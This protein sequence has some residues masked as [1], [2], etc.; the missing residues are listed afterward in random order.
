MKNNL[1]SF[2]TS[3]LSQDA[4]ICYLLNFAHQ[5]HL[6]EDPV[7]SQCAKQ[8]LALVIEDEKDLTITK[9]QRQ[10]KNIDILVEVNGKYHVIIEDKTFSNHHHDQINR[11]KNALIEEG[12]SNVVT[13]FYKIVE[14]P[15]QE[16]VDVTITRRDLIKL[17]SSFIDQTSNTIFNDYLEYLLEIEADVNSFKTAPMSIW[18]KEYNHVYKGFFS[19]LVDNRIVQLDRNWGWGYVPNQANGFWGFWWFFL[20][21][22]ELDSCQLKESVLDELYLQ[23]EDNAISIKMTGKTDKTNA[24]RWSLY[25]YF[26]EKV[27]GFEKK[28]FRQGRSMTI[29]Y[30]T[31]NETNYCDKIAVM[32]NAMMSLVHGE[33]QFK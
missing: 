33:Y 23:I 3:E 19:H 21:S 27:P 22:G 4:F 16:D 32:E 8:L 9:I 28:T 17:F 5:D 24:A 2:A 30:I 20:D 26:R 10:Y 1:F 25:E 12:R 29:G 7:L 13:V 6:D 31:Y 15:H 18:R 14:Q 11:Y